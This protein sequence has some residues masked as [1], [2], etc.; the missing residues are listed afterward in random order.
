MRVQ[1]AQPLTL[2]KL[3]SGAALAGW[4]IAALLGVV[5]WFLQREITQ[6]DQDHRQNVQDHI[7]IEGKIDAVA[8]D[9]GDLKATVGRISGQV[10]ILVDRARFSDAE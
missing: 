10:D 7:R 9:V 3:P 6:N 4:A 2:G 5:V 1:P 8:R